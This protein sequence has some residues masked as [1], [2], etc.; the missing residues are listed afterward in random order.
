MLA[1]WVRW[2]CLF[3]IHC[4]FKYLGVLGHH[5]VL[6]WTDGLATEL[7]H[8]FVARECLFHVQP[9]QNVVVLGWHAVA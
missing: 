4:A 9:I 7:F 6:I 5:L 2:A 8:S 3:V 1:R